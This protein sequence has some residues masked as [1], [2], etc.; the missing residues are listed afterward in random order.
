[1]DY[2]AIRSEM[3]QLKEVRKGG[4]RHALR[5]PTPA[6]P[7]TRPGLLT[8]VRQTSAPTPELSSDPG[9]TDLDPGTGGPP[10]R[11]HIPGLSG[12]HW[13]ALGRRLRCCGGRA[14]D[15]VGSAR[16]RNSGL[17]G[18]GCCG[19]VWPACLQAPDARSWARWGGVLCGIW[20]SGWGHGMDTGDRLGKDRHITSFIWTQPPSAVS[21]SSVNAV[22]PYQGQVGGL[23]CMWPL[24]GLPHC[25]SPCSA[26]SDLPTSY[27]S[28]IQCFLCPLPVLAA[29]SGPSLQLGDRSV[30]ACH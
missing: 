12:Q 22:R 10:N 11:P 14:P 30:D 21:Q 23:L 13:G 9:Q 17:C 7:H 2:E 25:P 4:R 3:E 27:F 8:R 26:L 19:A 20:L 5:A 6:N 1:M 24:P 28:G 29:F 15:V 16:C 18:K